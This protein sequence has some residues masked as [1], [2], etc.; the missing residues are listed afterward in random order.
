MTLHAELWSTNRTGNTFTKKSVWK[1][2]IN[3][4][5][6]CY[7]EFCETLRNKS[8]GEF[9]SF[10]NSHSEI[11]MEGAFTM[12]KVR[13]PCCEATVCPN[14]VFYEERPMMKDL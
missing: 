1:S 4:L 6:V 2:V 12:G 11:P 5:L 13:K 7:Q 9:R 14:D 10:S 8:L 3:R